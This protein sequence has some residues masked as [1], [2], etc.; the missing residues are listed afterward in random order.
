MVSDC[1]LV[2]MNSSELNVANRDLL[3]GVRINSEC[4][5]NMKTECSVFKL[6]EDNHIHVFDIAIC[7]I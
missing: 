2:S 6:C 4:Q 1:L 7:I 3:L 5:E